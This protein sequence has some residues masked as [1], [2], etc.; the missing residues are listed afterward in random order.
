MR[1]RIG[2]LVLP[3]AVAACTDNSPSQPDGPTTVVYAHAFAGATMGDKLAAAIQALPPAGGVVDA[4]D[5]TGA[6]RIDQ[7]I[8]LGSSGRSVE[9][10]LGSA[11]LSASVVPFMLAD[12]AKL[13]GNGGTIITQNNGANLEWL[14]RGV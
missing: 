10:R 11:T 9:L 13:I 1:W 3:F 5:F 12:R 2:G 14:V 8:V 6:Q 4:T 7:T